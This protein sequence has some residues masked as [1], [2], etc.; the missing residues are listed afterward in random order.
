MVDTSPGLVALVVVVISVVVAIV[1]VD[2]V[3]VVVSVVV[4]SEAIKTEDGSVVGI[5]GALL[6]SSLLYSAVSSLFAVFVVFDGG[7]GSCKFFESAMLSRYAICRDRCAVDCLE[8]N[9]S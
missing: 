2:S 3:V 7:T 1:V 6:S 8:V 9:R 4:W 5:I